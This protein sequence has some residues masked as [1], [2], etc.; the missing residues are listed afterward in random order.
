[1]LAIGDIVKD[2]DGTIGKV[3]E[4]REDWARYSCRPYLCLADLICKSKHA[5]RV[6]NFWNMEKNLTLMKEGER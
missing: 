6:R 2:R 3:I 5:M 1:M 4:V